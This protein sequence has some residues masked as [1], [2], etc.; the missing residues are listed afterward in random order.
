MGVAQL[1][2]QHV[3]LETYLG[4][5]SYGDTFADAV[6]ITCAY[7][8]ETKIVRT[9]SGEEV[10]SSTTVYAAIATAPDE[11]SVAGQ[12]APG[13][14]VTIGGKVAHVLATKRLEL[15]APRSAHHVEVNLT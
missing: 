11:D 12:F 4:A 3:S 15:P 10:T 8:A 1:F 2:K 5:N 6:T 9:A 14:R 7:F 13:S